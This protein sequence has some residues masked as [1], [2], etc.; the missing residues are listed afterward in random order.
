MEDQHGWAGL[1]GNTRLRILAAVVILLSLS[2]VVSILQIRAALNDRLDEEISSAL[3]R[4]VE[5]FVLLSSGRDPN[6]TE[7]F[8]ANLEALFDT[9]REVPDERET[10]IGMI[11]GVVYK[12]ENDPGALAAHELVEE[13]AHFSSVT[14]AGGGVLHTHGREAHYNVTPLVVDGLVAHFAAVN[15]PAAERR[16]IDEAVL[17]QALVQGLTILVASFLAYLAS[18]RVLRPLRSLAATARRISDTDLT[19][20]IPAGGRD[21]ASNIAG[22]FNDMLARLEAAFSTQRQFL[23]DASH[24]F[25]APLTVIRG[26][27][28]LLDMADDPQERAET[29]TLI[30]NEIDRMNRMVED[31]LTLARAERPDFLDL[32]EVD[33]REWTEEV[34]RK[35][36]VLGERDWVLDRAARIVVVADQQRLTQAIMQLAVNAT[37]HTGPG[38]RVRIG[39]AVEGDALRI[40]VRDDGPAVSEEDAQRIFHRFERGPTERRS[41]GLGL[42][43]VHAIAEAHGGRV[44]LDR[45]GSPG[46]RFELSM[47]IARDRTPTSLAGGQAGGGSPRSTLPTRASSSVSGNGLVT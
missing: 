32:A 9:D 4:E 31:L 29:I 2:S 21:E 20:R 37:Q 10:L 19:Q 36:A 25:R 43:I 15:F 33:V 30:T 23:D 6:T 8:G 28:E 17:T 16:E 47:P 12:Q 3:E 38:T 18:G 27:L 7:P 24:E 39:S 34:F 35:A 44:W 40:W 42:S 45:Q 13:V 46:A 14:R 11:D 1:F 41:T 5:E 26:H 22:A